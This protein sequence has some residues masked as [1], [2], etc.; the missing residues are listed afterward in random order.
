MNKMKWRVLYTN[1]TTL[2]IA[3]KFFLHSQ[4]R[5]RITNHTVVEF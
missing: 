3:N 1:Y 4:S 2:H 5:H